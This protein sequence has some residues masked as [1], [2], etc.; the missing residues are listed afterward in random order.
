MN[1]ELKEKHFEALKD[2]KVR[3]VYLMLCASCD[4]RDGGMTDADQM[5]VADYARAEQIK[6]MAIADIAER[7]LGEEREN[8][9]QSYYCENKSVGILRS[10]TEQQRKL[11]AELK[12]TPSSRKAST[13]QVSADEFDEF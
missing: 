13:V 12:L 5:L 3:G 10:Y 11:L 4:Q 2:E 1:F 6:Q 8:G 9:R 7:G